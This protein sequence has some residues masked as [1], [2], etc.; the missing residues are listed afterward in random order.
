MDIRYMAG[1]MAWTTVLIVNLLFLVVALFCALK[2]RVK[3]STGKPPYQGLNGRVQ[4]QGLAT[5]IFCAPNPFA[6]PLCPP[7][8]STWS[9]A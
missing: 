7:D 5:A 4:H 1:C 2:W 9:D 8:W 3:F 6:P